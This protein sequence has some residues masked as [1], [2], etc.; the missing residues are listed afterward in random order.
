MYAVLPAR[1]FSPAE[2]LEIPG[3]LLEEGE[4]GRA[5]PPKNRLANHSDQSPVMLTI[6]IDLRLALPRIKRKTAKKQEQ[7]LVSQT[8]TQSN[9]SQERR[10]RYASTKEG[11]RCPARAPH[12]P[13]KS[14][15]PFSR[16]YSLRTPSN[17]RGV[18]GP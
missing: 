12:V 3:N 6:H 8:S 5:P 9:P 13:L 15:P 16:Q 18:Q 10:K 1:P 17:A 4:V 11:R 2:T 7:K 14:G